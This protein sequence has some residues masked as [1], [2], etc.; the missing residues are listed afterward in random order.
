MIF[1]VADPQ[2]VLSSGN[3][4]AILALIVVT[5]VGVVIYLF[6]LLMAEKDKRLADA[7][8]DSEKYRQAVGDFSQ[9]TKLLLAKLDG[10]G[11]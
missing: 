6:K 4:V 10:E 2:T 5:L 3:A 7:I 8:A 11:K 1:A 9:T